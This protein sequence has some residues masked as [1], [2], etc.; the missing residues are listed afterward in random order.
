MEPI[1]APVK[2]P[3]AVPGAGGPPSRRRLSATALAQYVRFGNCD[4]LL[5]FTLHPEVA[6]ALEARWRISQQ[7]LTPLLHAAG[8]DFERGVV[9]RVQAASET[10]VDLAHRDV[11]ATVAQL[12]AGANGRR[13][14][15]AQAPL[16][17]AIGGWPCG[18]TA[19]LIWLLP[20]PPVEPSSFETGPASLSAIVVDVKASL[21][22]RV[23]HRL[24]VAFYARLLRHLAGQAGIALH[25]V[26]GAVLHREVGD[27]LPAIAPE[28]L[29]PFDLAPYD[30]ALEH[31]LAPQDGVV[32]RIAGQAFDDVSFSL[33]FKCDGCLF[34][35]HCMHESNA[36]ERVALVPYLAP[37][38]QRLLE[39]HGLRTFRDL[40]GLTRPAGPGQYRGPLAPAPGQETR[41]EQLRSH[42]QLGA[43]DRQ[44][45][46]ARALLRGRDRQRAER[47]IG[48]QAP[49]GKVPYEPA[50]DAPFST[51]PDEEAHPGLVKV[52]FDAQHDYVRDGVYLLAALV[53][54]PEGER[55]VV[56]R[57]A[58]PVDREGEG[59]LLERW[60]PQVYGAVVAMAGASESFVHLYTYSR[61]D[62][63]ILLAAL[64]RHAGA[65]PAIGAL[66]DLLTDTD[67]LASVSPLAQP[68]LSFLAEELRDRRTLDVTC[69]SLHAVASR[70]GFRWTGPLSSAGG[71]SPNG[72]GGP[73]VNFGERFRARIFDGR[74]LVDLGHQAPAAGAP[75]RDD[76][77]SEGAVSG[78]D[79][80][81]WIESAA[82]FRSQIPLEYAYGA[83][84]ALP[85]P[86]DRLQA[87]LLQPYADVT[88]DELEGFAQHRLRALV[89]V[90]GQ[91][92][93]KSRWAGKKPLPLLDLTAGALAPT[94]LPRALQDFLLIEHHARLQELLL[95]YAQPIER[96][97][98][99]GRGMLVQCLE[100]QDLG[101]GQA[102]AIGRVVFD[103][104]GLDPLLAEQA[105]R[106][107]EGDWV[108]VNPSS[109]VN[110]T[111][112]LHGRLATVDS[113]AATGTAPPRTPNEAPA[114]VLA[115]APGARDLFVHLGL[116]SLSL[117]GRVFAYSHRSREALEPGSFYTVDVMADDLNGDK[118]LAACRAAGDP[119][120]RPNPFLTWIERAE[121]AAD[122][123]GGER[124]NG[125]ERPADARRVAG[126]VRNP[127][128]YAAPATAC[129]QT[130]SEVERLAGGAEGEG[131][132]PTARQAEAIAGHLDQPVLLIQGPP[133]SGKSHTLGWAILVRL[134][135]ARLAGEDA[136]RVAV[137]SKTHNA[138]GIVLASVAEKLARLR[139]YAPASPFARALRDVRLYKLGGEEGRHPSGAGPSYESEGSP[140]DDD[141]VMAEVQPFDPYARRG[142]IEGLLAT[143]WLVAGG[144]PG[145]LYNLQRYRA[146]GGRDVPWDERPFDL[147][148]LDEA[149]QVSVAEALL[150]CA[151]VRPDGQALVV[152]DH[153][154]MPPIVA[155]AWNEEARRTVVDSEVYRSV[156]DLLRDRPFPRVGL[157]QSFRLPSQLASF[158]EEI[159][160]RQDGIPFYSQ[161]QERLA[162]LPSGD[163]FVDAA[164]DPAHA[165]VVVEHGDAT[166]HQFNQVELNLI[167]PLLEACSRG[168]RLDSARGIGV[169]VPHRAQRA[170][171]R[172][173]FPALAG[174]DAIDTVERFQGGERDVIVVSATASDPDYILSEAD[175]LLNPNRL[176][177]ALSRPRHKL[178]V[179]ASTT[180]LRLLT[181]DPDLFDQAALWKRLRYAFANAPLWSGERAGTTVQVFGCGPLP[182][183]D[184]ASS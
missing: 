26:S 43:L 62:Q 129:L 60:V 20:T 39:G 34:N 28:T 159:I 14:V 163:P 127:G 100:Y 44:T 11:G 122:G 4:R 23:E 183:P 51:L 178:I 124:A 139:R 16:S 68:M 87:R 176:N 93:P 179:L 123:E 5:Y 84:G 131:T 117:G 69:T 149:S 166:S 24:Q 150:A 85:A 56:E 27:A 97:A 74:R 155:V 3:D 114:G 32:P 18:G 61:Q 118:L 63:S 88:W 152:G 134:A 91:L 76:S 90:E 144:T 10:V 121:R 78:A 147:V 138:I 42:W 54:G 8:E 135:A 73:S 101:N 141:P 29:A 172:A 136:Y 94:T 173:R 49:A 181:S 160:Y 65:L 102:R 13:L 156:F 41:L 119:G 161:R 153:R 167:S 140:G 53:Q 143:P 108:V 83:W 17:G 132:G 52:F 128:R 48:G 7:P 111:R 70:L 67:A 154:Q 110:P 104:L 170:M 115:E 25:S 137:S 96:R 89:H 80:R 40:A 45:Q 58:A 36:R 145:G 99:T 182:A 12:R 82:R 66:F 21:N 148:V 55:V 75:S 31:L 113:L 9:A 174:A 95:T 146:A 103:Q 64:R 164:L 47:G 86:A 133:G 169:V 98:Q 105:L 15:L 72:P 46:R 71:A 168:L 151:S 33:S 37:A 92:R 59:E 177:V 1:A 162:Y 130:L 175:F 142:E 22:E 180:L 6:R 38:E 77:P 2:G 165:V 30:L 112:I 106:F 171:L 120:L 109:Q 116:K 107:K 50:I 158:L 81:T 157:D 79:N 57:T 125:A 19:D 184:G 126:G 35:A